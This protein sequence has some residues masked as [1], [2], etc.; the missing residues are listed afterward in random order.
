M[1]GSPVAATSASAF[2]RALSSRVS[3]D[4]S[5]SGTSAGRGSSSTSSP[6]IAW[7]SRALSGLAV[8]R[9]NLTSTRRRLGQVLLLLG[10]DALDAR[11]GQR[12]EVVELA[13]GEGQA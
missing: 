2:R 3:P 4:S 9:T 6:R 12:Q 7:I 11:L 13:A 10:H 1:A 8:A 5:T